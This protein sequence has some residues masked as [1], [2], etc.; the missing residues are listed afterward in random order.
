[1]EYKI[2]EVVEKLGLAK[3]VNTI[4]DVMQASD[5]LQAVSA[6]M[7]CLTFLPR[8]DQKF[9]EVSLAVRVPPGWQELYEAEG[10][11]H[12]DPCLRYCHSVVEPFEW[13]EA[14]F[15][16]EKEP[17]CAEVADRAR[18]FNVANGIVVPIPGPTG[19]IVGVWIGSHKRTDLIQLKPIIHLVA[20][21]AFHRTS[22]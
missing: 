21:Y 2:L 7:F 15:D 20:L 12:T 8:P 16:R 4:L 9:E 1:M 17:E 18:D 14:P 11:C 6:D 22:S 19:C 13:R 5:V 3:T 10:F